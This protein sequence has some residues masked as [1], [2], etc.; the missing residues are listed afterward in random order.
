MKLC[1]FAVYDKAVNAYLQPFFARHTNEAVRSF[2]DACNDEKHQFF[3]H[4]TD[5]L[6]MRLGEFEDA[7]GL[8]SC[9]EPVR[10]VSASECLSG[11]EEK[12]RM[13]MTLDDMKAI[14]ARGNGSLAP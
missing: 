1:C 13:E 3:R 10:I 6:L 11:G 14:V 4:A 9:G 7:T 12:P 8:F 5:Y 2:A